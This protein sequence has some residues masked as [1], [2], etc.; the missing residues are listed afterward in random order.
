MYKENELT[1]S[2]INLLIYTGKLCHVN[3]MESEKIEYEAE[4]GIESYLW[5]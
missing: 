3:Q 2:L 4:M 5:N 1:A